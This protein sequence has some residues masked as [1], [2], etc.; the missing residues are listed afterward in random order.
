MNEKI[1]LVDDEPDILELVGYNLKKEGYLIYKAPDGKKAIDIANNVLPDLIIIDI[2]MPKMDGIETCIELR[3]NEKLK[4]TLIAF[5]TA[6]AEDYSSCY[7]ANQIKYT[8]KEENYYNPIFVKEENYYNP[9]FRCGKTTG[10][11]DV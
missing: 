8:V 3:K 2:M 10:F 11:K 5:L 9:I 7:S 4:T 6:R 1:L